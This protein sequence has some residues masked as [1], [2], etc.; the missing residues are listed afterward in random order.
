MQQPVAVMLQVP[1]NPMMGI[2]IPAGHWMVAYGYDEE[3]V[4]LTNWWQD[5]MTWQEF[6]Q[7]WES[8]ISWSI[9]MDRK[10]LLLRPWVR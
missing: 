1:G 4:Y 6:R 3:S 10:G 5:S 8:L 9:N 2:S 7:G